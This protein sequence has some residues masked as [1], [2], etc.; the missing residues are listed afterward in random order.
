MLDGKTVCEL[1]VD[2]LNPPS[3]V[4]ATVHPREASG[5]PLKLSDSEKV[6]AP[7]V[8][9]ATGA[10]PKR[11]AKAAPRQEVATALMPL[12][13]EAFEQTGWSRTELDGIVVGVGPG[14]FTGI[15]TGVV[16]ARTLAQS[17]NLP[18]I[19]ISLLEVYASEIELPSGLIMA[20]GKGHYFIGGYEQDES[21]RVPIVSNGGANSVPT[22]RETFSSTYISQHEIAAALARMPHWAAEAAIY[23]EL[24]EAVAQSDQSSAVSLIALPIVKNIATRQAQIA[25]NRLSLTLA[26][27]GYEGSLDCSEKQSGSISSKNSDWKPF[28]LKQFPFRNV[29]PLYL[30]DPSV[31]VK[32]TNT[33]AATNATENPADAPGRPR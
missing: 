11:N 22:L 14:S 19:P 2:R 32:S 33:Q 25:W 3:D 18:L 1:S 31:T 23:W 24:T 26:Q 7:S 9:Y 16:T 6:Q 28:L 27:A 20:A 5:E 13:D 8:M 12:V 15:R 17:M 4:K 10:K 21:V 30:R 29:Q